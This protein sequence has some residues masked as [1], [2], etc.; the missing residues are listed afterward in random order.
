MSYCITISTSAVLIKLWTIYFCVKNYVVIMDPTGNL[1]LIC[2]ALWTLLRGS[3]MHTFDPLCV[4]K[5]FTGCKPGDT[6]RDG[7]L[8]LL[9]DQMEWFR[10]SYEIISGGVVTAGI[11]ASVCTRVIRLILITWFTIKPAK[12]DW[13]LKICWIVKEWSRSRAPRGNI[14]FY[15]EA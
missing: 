15:K 8:L 7:S 9:N 12:I 14:G 13:I 6:Q 4:S 1:V 5:W 3:L 11:R 10:R 2:E